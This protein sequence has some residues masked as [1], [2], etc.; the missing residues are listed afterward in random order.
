MEAPVT[1]EVVMPLGEIVPGWGIVSEAGFGWTQR[2]VE[3]I[4]WAVGFKA[5]DDAAVAYTACCGV[6]MDAGLSFHRFVRPRP[7]RAE[8]W[9][10]RSDRHVSSV[11]QVLKVVVQEE[12]ICGNR[13]IAALRS[14]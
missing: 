14:Q 12:V 5:R 9:P 8:A 10:P 11:V 7:P 4:A 1:C 2:T 3:W 13:R 6:C